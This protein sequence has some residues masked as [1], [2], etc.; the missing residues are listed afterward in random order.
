MV[1]PTKL[2]LRP[3]PGQTVQRTV[4]LVNYT[5]QSITLDLELFE[6]TQ[7][8]QGHWRVIE[9]GSASDASDSHSCLSWISLSAKNVELKPM[10][11][12]PVTV[13]LKV[14]FR[15]HGFYKGALTV[16]TRP[17][18]PKRG[19]IGIVIR[20]LI[21]ILVELKGRPVRQKIELTNANMQFVEQSGKK[22]PTTLVSM[23]VANKGET[24]PRLKGSINIMYQVGKHWRKLTSAEFRKVSI[25]PG[26]ELSL[27][28]DL[29][30]RF[31]SG[32]YK[33][34]GTLYV[35]GRRVRPLVKEIDFAGDPTVEKVA[36]DV[37]LVLDPAILSIEAVPGGVRAAGVKIQN[38]SEE[39]VDVSVGAKTPGPFRG[40]SLGKIK[41]E[42][43]S[44]AEWIKVIPANFMLTPGRHRTVRITARLPKDEKLYP[45]YYAT[46]N[47]GAKYPDGQSAGENTSL[48]WLRNAKI[49]AEPAAQ[50]MEVSLAAEEDSKYVIQAESANIGNVHF[51]P[52][53][54]AAVTNSDGVLVLGTALSGQGQ[55]ML[56]LEIR[57][58]SGIL[59]FSK[60]EEGIYRLSVLMDYGEKADEVNKILPIQIS[61]K[62]GEKI[63]AVIPVNEK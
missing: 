16:Q 59:D 54:K 51:I 46:L 30:R 50:I 45:N 48:I 5:A 35:N 4:E 23:N 57:D 8:E 28:S 22:P 21:P 25:I 10:Q 7:D 38:L 41:G 11:R 12:A 31:P 42:D 62:E 63:V 34:R 14:P 3:Y 9:S 20:F 43:L 18:E 1:R 29:E 47:F 49:N 27:K 44:C 13:T 61:V 17:P 33:L 19:R 2:E 53:C 15:A 58:F 26:V 60:A 37:P 24:C 36:A 40:V 52:E 56:P 39:T 6:L 32:K 55:V